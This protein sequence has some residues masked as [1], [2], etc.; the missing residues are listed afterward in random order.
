VKACGRPWSNQCSS[1][2]FYNIGCSSSSL[3]A[4]LPWGNNLA[5]PAIKCYGNPFGTSLS[6]SH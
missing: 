3:S 4:T 5:T 1:F 2:K 6:W